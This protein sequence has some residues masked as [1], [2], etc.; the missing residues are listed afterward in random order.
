MTTT[1]LT[2]KG[3]QTSAKVFTGHVEKAAEDQIHKF[4]DCPAFADA[5]IRIMPDVHAGSGAVIGFTCPVSDKI[6]P[7]VI[8]VDIGCGVLTAQTDQFE[9][10]LN[11]EGFGRFDAQL[12]HLVPSGFA[13]QQ[14]INTS[15]EKLYLGMIEQHHGFD[16]QNF[17]AAV[18][19][20]APKIHQ[21]VDQIWKQIGTLGGGN[22]FIEI[23]VATADGPH[24]PTFLTIHTGSRNFGLRIADYHQK[25]AQDIMAGGDRKNELAWLEGDDALEYL[26]DMRIAQTFARLNRLVIMNELTGQGLLRSPSQI[27]E[28]VHNYIDDDNII[29]KGAVSAKKDQLVVIP[30]NMRDGLIIGTGKGNEDWNCSA[31]HGAGRTMSRNQAKRT[32]SVDDFRKSM[33]SVWSSCIGENTLDEAPDAYKPRDQIMSLIADAVDVQVVARPVY[34]FKAAEERK[35]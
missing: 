17:V 11:P 2:F 20:I 26:A 15:I 25:K 8:G 12:R 22:H 21:D 13:H 5:K 1:F 4:L 29:R 33:S 24:P 18:E 6:I 35:Y 3:T 31:P 14:A 32:L 30:W 34:N 16:Y 28:S 19:R 9:G 23:D 27:I 7:N 10:H